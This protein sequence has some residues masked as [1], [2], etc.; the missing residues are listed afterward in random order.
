M[1]LSSLLL[2]LLP[3][4]KSK[5]SHEFSILCYP[6]HSGAITGVDVC[7]RKPLGEGLCVLC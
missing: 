2:L 3:G 1:R 6:F 5:G 7:H 4:S